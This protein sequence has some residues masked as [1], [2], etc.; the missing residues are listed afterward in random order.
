MQ[1]RTDV[2][3]GRNLKYKFG[4]NT[5]LSL[6]AIAASGVLTQLQAFFFSKSYL[7]NN[8]AKLVSNGHT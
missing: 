4:P 5:P 2:G 8:S 3:V 1:I 7:N 6:H